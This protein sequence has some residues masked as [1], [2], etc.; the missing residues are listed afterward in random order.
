MRLAAVICLVC[1][2]AFPA[3]ARECR[4]TVRAWPDPVPSSFLRCLLDEIADL[5]AS[6]SRLERQV[7]RLREDL[8]VAQAA[9]AEL[10]GTY[11][12]DNGRVSVDEGR[13]LASARLILPARQTG[14]VGALAV[15]REVIET[16]CSGTGGCTLSLLLHSDGPLG[17]GAADVAASGPCLFAYDAQGGAWMRS[18]DCGA[19]GNA[20][21]TDGNGTPSGDDGSEIVASAGGGCLLA[22]SDPGLSVG[23]GT[24]PLGRDHAR[25]FYLVAAPALRRDGAA[26]FR[27]ELKIK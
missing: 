3:S 22:D 7:G 20:S 1:L 15:D 23:P 12:N 9:L 19:V 21:G 17:G 5:K 14:D 6:Q 13:R 8:A 24:G 18:G 11:V 16:L 4:L 25:G 10:P 27:C 2:A 26:R